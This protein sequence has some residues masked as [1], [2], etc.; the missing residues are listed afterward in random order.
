MKKLFLVFAVAAM[1]MVGCKK[2]DSGNKG[3]NGNKGGG[4][5][6]EYVAPIAI[7]GDFADWAKLDASKVA[8]A[9]L[10]EGAAKEALKL[11]KV[12]AD[13]M[14]V[15]VYFEWDKELVEYNADEFVPF[16]VYLNSDGDAATGGFG[17]QFSDASIDFLAEGM[18]TDGKKIVNYGDGVS[19]FSWIGETNGTGWDWE[20]LESG[21]GLFEGAGVVGKYELAITRELFPLGTLADD[22]TIGFDIQQA[23]DSVGVLPIGAEGYVASLAV[24]TDK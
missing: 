11:V 6:P 20:E 24:S 15:F 14:Y 12:Y 19:C 2:D 5:D 3:N 13:E 23:W 17:D 22:F 9:T 4:D 8:T 21:D 7:D 1:C 16:H 10:P 18:L